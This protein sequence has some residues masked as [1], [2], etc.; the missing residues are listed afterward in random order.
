MSTN[1]QDGRISDEDKYRDFAQ[2]T[3]T[4]SA[5]S[6]FTTDTIGTINGSQCYLDFTGYALFQPVRYR[7]VMFMK[8]LDVTCN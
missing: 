1:V 2:N 7:L 5:V 4:N 6:Y 3:I 8:G